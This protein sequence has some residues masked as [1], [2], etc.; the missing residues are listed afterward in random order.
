[1]SQNR[2]PAIDI[3][4]FIAVFLVMNSHM[5]MCYPK[6]Q[7]LAT[8]GGIGDALFFFASGFTLFLGRDLRF[9]QWYKRRINRIYPSILA[10]AIVA[11]LVWGF[12][13]NIV[14]IL[15][16]KRYWFIGCI[17]IYYVFLYPLKKINNE[18]IIIWIFAGWLIVLAIAYFAL[19]GGSVSLYSKGLY[20]CLIYF[21]F[22][23][24]GAIMGKHSD[25]I[26]CK[27]W[28]LPSLLVA[29][30]LWFF[31]L[32]IGTGNTLLIISIL[33]LLYVTYSLYCLCN[34][35]ILTK[36]YDTKVVGSFIFIV[37]QLCLEVYL[38]QK[39]VFTDSINNLFPWNVPIIMLI[40]IIAAYFV[41]VLAE[42]IS[43]TFRTEPYEWNKM[44]LYKR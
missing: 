29:T 6:F 4:K 27:W 44:L 42:F 25:S 30:G 28:H 32:H 18:K 15:I 38:I 8:G 39:F 35:R 7:F 11:C 40:V 41:K 12:E 34:A 21:L 17:M 14:D 13:E 20:R 5:E 22:M 3:L 23:L 37:S 43:Q 10:V 19:W 1:M 24:Q 2:V 9:D 33:P 16:G 31:L 36:L 26:S